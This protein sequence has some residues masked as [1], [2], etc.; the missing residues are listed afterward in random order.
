M[1]ALVDPAATY[2]HDGALVVAVAVK[3]V[4]VMVNE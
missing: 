2:L 3:V 1:A 4:V